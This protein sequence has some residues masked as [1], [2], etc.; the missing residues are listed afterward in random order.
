MKR[1]CWTSRE[2]QGRG[3][4]AHRSAFKGNMGDVII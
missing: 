2:P 1:D 4:G 3:A